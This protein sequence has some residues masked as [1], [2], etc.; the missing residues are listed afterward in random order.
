MWTSCDQVNI[1]C[2]FFFQAEDGIRGYDVTGVQTCALP[3][4]PLEENSYGKHVYHLYVIITSDRKKL[5]AHLDNNGIQNLIHYPIPINK[6]K[7]FFFQ[8]DEKFP[9]SERLAEEILSIP[10]HHMLK[11]EEMI[12]IVKYINEYNY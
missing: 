11:R 8:K 9:N 4:L 10:I 12:K 7:A 5:Q 3:I 2:C 6:Q 1:L